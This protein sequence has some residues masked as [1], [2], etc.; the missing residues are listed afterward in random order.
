MNLV[1]NLDNGDEYTYDALPE[2][3][4]VFAFRQYVKK[5]FNTWD[6]D[7]QTKGTLSLS[8]ETVSYGPF[9]CIINKPKQGEL[10]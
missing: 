3:A 5:D 1:V 7:K 4:V 2:Y 10:F 8:G 9:T 6:Y